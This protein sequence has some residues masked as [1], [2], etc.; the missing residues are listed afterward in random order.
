MFW[1]ERIN[2]SLAILRTM[3]SR[4]K[5]DW[6][7]SLRMDVSDGWEEKSLKKYNQSSIRR[8]GWTCDLGNSNASSCKIIYLC[9]SIW[10]KKKSIRFKPRKIGKYDVIKQIISDLLIA[11]CSTVHSMNT[12]SMAWVGKEILE[13]QEKCCITL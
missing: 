7:W 13:S 2:T 5:G 3:S 11:T 9:K 1:E 10:R 8:N 4:G 12:A 6:K